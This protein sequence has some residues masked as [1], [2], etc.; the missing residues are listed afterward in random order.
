MGG[1]A[2]ASVCSRAASGGLIRRGPR[3]GIAP[4]RVAGPRQSGVTGRR[5]DSIDRPNGAG[6]AGENRAGVGVPDSA[7][8]GGTT[9]RGHG[10]G[11]AWV[12][13]QQ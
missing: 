4:R 8:D 3:R 5:G 2:D 7:Y 9:P 13:T 1:R 6:P 12:I 11:G 10:P